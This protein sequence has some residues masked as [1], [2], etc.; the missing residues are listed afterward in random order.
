MQSESRSCSVA[1]VR[2]P[3]TYIKKLACLQYRILQH[4]FF[5][6]K[7]MLHCQRNQKIGEIYTCLV[8]KSTELWINPSTTPASHQEIW[9]KYKDNLKKPSLQNQSLEFLRD[10]STYIVAIRKQ[11]LQRSPST[12]SRNSPIYNQQN[13]T[14]PFL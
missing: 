13:L 8:C 9:Y 2:S 7:R 12:T 4:R 10:R 11:K 1:V 5:L 6:W 3:A 14:T